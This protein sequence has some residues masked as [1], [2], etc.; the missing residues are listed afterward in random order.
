VNPGESATGTKPGDESAVPILGLFQGFGVELELMIVDADTLD[1]RPVAD[2]LMAAAAGAVVSECERDDL[3]WSNELVLHVFEI[4]TNG[5]APSLAGLA[6]RFHADV[7]EA[8]GLLEPLGCRLLGGGAHPWMDPGTETRIWPHEYGEVYHTYDRI[9]SCRGHGWSN[10]QATHLNLP[11]SG[12]REFAALHAATR[13]VL[14][15][16]PALA[17]STPFLDGHRQPHLDERMERYRTNA[18]R[19][20]SMAGA[21]VP[22]AIDSRRRYEKEV[23]GPLYEALAPLDP[24]GVLRHEWANARGA[25]ARFQRG[26]VEIRVVD[27]QECPSADLAIL[28]LTTE[29]VRRLAE[30][31]LPNASRL[32]AVPTDELARILG[33]TVRE[34]ERARVDQPRYLERLG[35]PGTAPRSAGAIWRELAAGI[36]T[37]PGEP[38]EEWAE[39]LG[40]IL[41][42][43][44]LA[45]RLLRAAGPAPDRPR[46]RRVYGA[47][48]DCLRDDRP[49]RPR[50]SPRTAT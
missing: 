38:L 34:G 31:A 12:D 20:P 49:F 21:V 41:E 30:G 35:I 25:I 18:I 27:A 10:L 23:L 45:R 24:E 28:A 16:L 32:D 42:A 33:A 19:V 6:G 17:A 11:F 22:E 44:P 26:T 48:A 2:R 40:V 47:L 7:L 5:P 43:G 29:V 13:L 9:F 14:P 3:A 37:G 1:V 15:L 4:K 46:L 50:A 36:G 39:P 8:E